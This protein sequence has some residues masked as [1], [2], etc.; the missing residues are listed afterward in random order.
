MSFDAPVPVVV[1]DKACWWREAALNALRR[2]RVA[3]RVT[4]TSESA[5]GVEAVVEAGL[6][7]G[8]VSQDQLRTEFAAFERFPAGPRSYLVRAQRRDV[9][10]ALAKPMRDAIAEA[11]RSS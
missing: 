9:D 5:S 4:Y 10:E 7:V 3:Y 1:Y 11:F 6:A 8:R 2:S